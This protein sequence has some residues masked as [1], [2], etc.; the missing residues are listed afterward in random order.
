MS[1]RKTSP[2]RPLT[3]DKPRT[4]RVEIF[5]TPAERDRINAALNGES[6]SN[7]IRRIVLDRLGETS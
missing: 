6:R 5:F 3:A 2:G 1:A 7:W 4:D